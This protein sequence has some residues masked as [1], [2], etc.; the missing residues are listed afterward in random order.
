MSDNEKQQIIDEEQLRL[1]SF[2]HYVSG[3]V[4]I[5]F[6]S[7]FIFHLIFFGYM[8]SN[9]ELFSNDDAKNAK[10]AMQIM[11][12]LLAVF[13]TFV[14]LGISYGICE[15]VSGVFIKQKKYRIFSMIVA[16]PRIILIPYGTILSMFT[17]ILLDRD[18]VKSLYEKTD[19]A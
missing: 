18:S 4:T 1:L 15:I 10:E 2:F 3:A 8:A 17:F 5:T 14:I 16:I 12:I 9:P 7:M 11:Q 19:S 13:G 6:S